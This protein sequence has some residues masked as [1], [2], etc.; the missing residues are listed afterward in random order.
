[1]KVE[2]ESAVAR[3]EREQREYEE[4]LKK[5]PTP[6]RERLEA[7]KKKFDKQIDVKAQPKKISLKTS[8]SE[9]SLNTKSKKNGDSKPA[10]SDSAVSVAA[11]VKKSNVTD[12][13]VQLHKKRKAAGESPG[14]GSAPT[15]RNQLLRSASRSPSPQ[16]ESEP[17]GRRR[18]VVPP[19]AAVKSR[20][21]VSVRNAAAEEESDRSPSPPARLAS[22]RRKTSGNSVGSAGEGAGLGGR[23]ILVLRKERNREKSPEEEEEVSPKREMKKSL[24]MRLG[25]KVEQFTENEILAEMLRQ[26]EEKRKEK[27]L[28]REIKELKKREKHERKDKKK[29]KKKR[30]ALSD[31]E[32]SDRGNKDDDSDEELYRFFEDKD[33]SPS[34]EPKKKKKKRNSSGRE[35]RVSSGEKRRLVLSSETGAGKPR[36]R[37]V[38]KED[39]GGERRGGRDAKKRKSEDAPDKES[40]AESLDI[41]EKMKRKSERRLRRMREIEQ[42]KLM[43]A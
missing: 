22:K 30:T 7:R 14:R 38:E 32:L 12:L 8:K 6:E 9:L 40:D 24:H 34:P 35:G 33:S 41:V 11:E 10:S 42:D 27:K 26:Q 31:D 5:L 17:A 19:G 36:S 25:G 43:F 16:P 23:R 1:M 39:W 29:S 15:D 20:L 18:K 2:T 28:R 3:A 37:P 21:K 13:R 4:R